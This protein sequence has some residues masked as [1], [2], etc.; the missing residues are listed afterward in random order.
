MKKMTKSDVEQ[1][2]KADA[3]RDA[4]KLN[5]TAF[6]LEKMT[7]DAESEMARSMARTALALTENVDAK[8]A[9]VYT[10]TY[11]SAL[12]GVWSMTVKALERKREEFRRVQN[13]LTQEQ[14][15]EKI[16]TLVEGFHLR[17]LRR[18]DATGGGVSVSVERAWAVSA[19]LYIRFERADGEVINPDD[20]HWHGSYLTVTTQLT[21]SSTGR[22][23][24][25]GLAA[26]KLYQEMLDVAA[27]VEAVMSHERVAWTYWLPVTEPVD[28]AK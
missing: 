23:V 2:A 7:W 6:E 17:G 4:D 10:E 24:V 19:D 14:A 26:V 3:R 16:K 1:L 25:E 15:A 8:F 28:E 21:W 22:T 11:Y 9:A 20:E 27:E 5:K 18:L 13:A 12:L